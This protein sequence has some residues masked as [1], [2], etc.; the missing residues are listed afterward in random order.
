MAAVS[1]QLIEVLYEPIVAL[2]S[3]WV[4]RMVPSSEGGIG[5]V[6]MFNCAFCT[7]PF[8]CESE[9][10]IANAAPAFCYN[11]ACQNKGAI[12]C[13]LDPGLCNPICNIFVG[14]TCQGHDTNPIKYSPLTTITTTCAIAFSLITDPNQ[15][16]HN[17][18]QIFTG[19]DG[20]RKLLCCMGNKEQISPTDCGKFWGPNNTNGA[21]DQVMVN[22]C[23]LNPADPLCNCL[24]STIP[25]PQ[26]NDKRCANTD[27]MKKSSMFTECNDITINCQQIVEIG[28]DTA[29]NIVD[30]VL[31]QLNCNLTTTVGPDPATVV[32]GAVTSPVGAGAVVGIIVAVVIMGYL[33]A[34]AII[35]TYQPSRRKPMIRRKTTNVQKQRS[36]IVNKKK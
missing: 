17:I 29:N 27:A 14:C 36:N 24:T 3:T 28:I 30:N 1:S 8:C 20:T 5:E 13:N 34:V 21:C 23:N 25:F 10:P 6:V 4:S 26:C 22:Y 11:C 7:N 35:F 9:S 16:V 31:Q 2:P 32:T 15:R 33:L 19:C 12:K 18:R